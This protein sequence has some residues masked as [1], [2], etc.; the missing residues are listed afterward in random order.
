MD[1]K[2]LLELAYPNIVTSSPINDFTSICCRTSRILSK[3]STNL[4]KMLL[5]SIL[6]VAAM[7]S[8]AF[9]GFDI[10][11]GQTE[12]WYTDDAEVYT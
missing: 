1:V 10:Q 12:W 9:A 3:S 4:Y 2:F 5:E 6:V 7:T 8:S 11:T